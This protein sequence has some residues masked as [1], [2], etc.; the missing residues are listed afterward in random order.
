M[1]VDFQNHFTQKI[2]LL[3]PKKL[4]LWLEAYETLKLSYMQQSQKHQCLDW[5]HPHDCFLFAKVATKTTRNYDSI[6]KPTS[7]MVVDEYKSK[8][9]SG[10]MITKPSA[11]MMRD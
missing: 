3:Q 9:K 11:N 5:F 8:L 6:V 2:N 7:N 10:K 4:K 1:K